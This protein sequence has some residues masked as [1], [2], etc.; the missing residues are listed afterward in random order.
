[1]GSVGWVPAWQ[2][3]G[4]QKHS[5]RSHIRAR[6][7]PAASL[8][9]TARHCYPKRT[10]TAPLLSSAPSPPTFGSRLEQ[11][12][13]AH[14]YLGSFGSSVVT[15]WFGA[16]QHGTNQH[17]ALCLAGHQ[18]QTW[19]RAEELKRTIPHLRPIQAPS[20]WFWLFQSDHSADPGPLSPLPLC[21]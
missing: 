15:Q 21:P 1:M 6:T 16:S 13:G 5:Q 4:R 10:C 17:S 19:R 3:V 12:S 2:A 9:T 7:A 14:P 20:P 11:A 8:K 18:H